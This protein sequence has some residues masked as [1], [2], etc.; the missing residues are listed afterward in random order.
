V[1][2]F[3]AVAS[4][5]GSLSPNYG[6]FVVNSNGVEFRD[7]PFIGTT[8]YVPLA[9]GV[10]LRMLNCEI[11]KYDASSRLVLSRVSDG[12]NILLGQV[13]VSAYLIT[14]YGAN[15]NAASGGWTFAVSNAGTCNWGSTASG[16]TYEGKTLDTALRIQAPSSQTTSA[17]SPKIAVQPERIY[18]LRGLIKTG[19]SGATV[20]VS[21]NFYKW[22]DAA[23]STAS[24]SIIS[25]P[26][27]QFGATTQHLLGRVT[28]PKD[29]VKAELVLYV[30]NVATA[31][32]TGLSLS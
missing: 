19:T 28:M 12:P 22:N 7:Q 16:I 11:T 8:T 25:C 29:A 1:S 30:E 17:T 9:Q 5:G 15:G 26:E 31:Y 24:A 18:I 14:A 27:S 23:A 21:V 2:A 13:D 20:K 6:G 3:R 4:L 10:E 32:F